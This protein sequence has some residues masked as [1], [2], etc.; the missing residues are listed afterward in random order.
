VRI[1]TL[2]TAKHGKRSRNYVIQAVQ[3]LDA[4]NQSNARSL[5]GAPGVLAYPALG[6]PADARGDLDARQMT[7]GV[8]TEAA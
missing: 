5:G 1:T 4:R 7:T 2:W 8:P 6:G 3:R